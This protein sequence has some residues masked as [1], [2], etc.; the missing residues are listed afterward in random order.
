MLNNAPVPMPETHKKILTGPNGVKYV[1]HITNCYRDLETKKPKHTSVAIGKIDEATGLLIP[2]ANYPKYYHANNTIKKQ[3]NINQNAALPNNAFKNNIVSPGHNNISLDYGNYI[4]LNQLAT[5]LELDKFLKEAFPDKY[6]QILKIAFYMATEGNALHRI[7]EWQQQ[8][9]SEGGPG[10]FIDN[11]R[12]SELFADIKFAEIQNFCEYW[13]EKYAKTGQIA[14]DVTAVQ[15]YSTQRNMLQH[16]YKGKNLKLP[17]INLAMYYGQESLLPVYYRIYEG[18]INDKADMEFM[19]Q[20]T[21]ALGLQNVTFVIDRGFYSKQN[22]SCIIKND[23]D[24]ILPLPTSVK[25]YYSLLNDCLDHITFNEYKIPSYNTYGKALDCCIGGVKLKAHVFFDIDKYSTDSKDFYHYYYK[26]IEELK[27]LKK[28]KKQMAKFKKMFDLTESND[29]LLVYDFQPNNDKINAIKKYN[30]F[31]IIL[32]TDKE[33]TSEFILKS[34]KRRNSIEKQFMIFKS[35]LDFERCRTQNDNTTEGKMFVQ[36]ISWILKTYMYNKLKS[37]QN[38]NIQRLP[39][40]IIIR[41]LKSYRY[42][43]AN[44]SYYLTTKPKILKDILSAL[45]IQET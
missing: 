18:S 11:R 4:V 12:C 2:N 42:I 14:Y 15:G 17:Q 29:Q 37:C 43:T 39:M 44:N 33:V 6:E 1:Y 45:G 10:G 31:F 38:K 25:L 7:E 5:E 19:I 28:P 21:R 13:M 40:D 30:G 3:I 16:G 41:K 20:H 26:L 8:T 34:Y 22:I 27:S 9:Y 24:I 32:S 23:F 35:V 36:F